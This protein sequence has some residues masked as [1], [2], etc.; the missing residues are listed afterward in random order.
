MRSSDFPVLE[1][2]GYAIV[3]TLWQF[4]L[5]WLVYV[6]LSSLVKLSSRLKYVVGYSLQTFGFACF[7]GTF[8]TCF[9][10]YL[11]SAE[12]INPVQLKNSY[13]NLGNTWSKIENLAGLI[14][15]TEKLL[16]YLA[17]SY[18]A[19]LLFLFTR[20]LQSFYETK[21]LRKTGLK[22]ID[23]S[24]KAFVEELSSKLNIS[25]EVKI[26][27]SEL[28]NT[29]LTVGFLKPLI[30]IPIASMSNLTSQQLE[31]LI[32]HELAHIKRYDYIFNLFLAFIETA[33]FFN[34]FMRLISMQI[35]RERENCCD[36]YV[37]QHKYSPASYARALLHLASCRSSAPLLALK[38][39][40]DKQILLTRVKRIIEKKE[41]TFFNFRHQLM[42]LLVM[43]AILI[44]PVFLSGTL[45]DQ[46]FTSSQNAN[47]PFSFINRNSYSF[48]GENFKVMPDNKQTPFEG[49]KFLKFNKANS[50]ILEQVDDARN[51]AGR[52]SLPKNADTRL[53][54]KN[55]KSGDN[56][57]E[58]KAN[59]LNENFD[60]SVT[61][62]LHNDIQ[63]E[64]EEA[65]N[66][67]QN[68][69]NEN[70]PLIDQQ[71]V[72]ASMKAALDQIEVAKRQQQPLKL[73]TIAS[74]GKLKFS[75]LEKELSSS[76]KDLDKKD[77]LETLMKQIQ[78]EIEE[79]NRNNF[80]T[81][82]E[83]SELQSDFQTPVISPA[84]PDNPHHF[85]FE[86]SPVPKATA[87]GY[88]QSLKLSNKK[89]VKKVVSPKNKDEEESTANRLILKISAQRFSHLR[90]VRI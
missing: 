46:S 54:T 41:R 47:I 53:I 76:F 51:P 88:L 32:L 84:M 6:S 33:L 48:N 25:R 81:F 50:N 14:R 34:P 49:E 15:E 80:L 78:K 8:I 28:V 1:A 72:L 90:V 12:D 63:F 35:Q 16:P 64:E 22:E 30:L 4:A 11:I 44:L 79:V 17:M 38:A 43:T 68:F 75:R 56:L 3:N 36:D 18:I 69:D 40:D 70:K 65:Q 10:S 2:L 26:Y 86:F 13:L 31:A 67:S 61:D 59:G 73:L 9:K 55:S 23:A 74:L 42:A 60:K 29:P 62:E 87:T 7:V 21:A 66:F 39:A 52:N 20:F 27:L 83:N 77:Q 89:N 57:I 19:L 24:W 45:S 37:L 5:L 71:K 85:S 58:K 82:Q